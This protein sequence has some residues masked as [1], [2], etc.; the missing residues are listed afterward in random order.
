M[1]AASRDTRDLM[2]DAEAKAGRWLADGNAAEER[3][4]KA[5]ARRCFSRAQTW[6]DRATELRQDMEMNAQ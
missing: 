5:T 3:G 4:A 2:L 6:H 1:S